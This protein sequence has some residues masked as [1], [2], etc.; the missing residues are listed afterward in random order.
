MGIRFRDRAC[1]YVRFSVTG[2]APERFLNL[3]G[4]KG[5]RLWD[6]CCGR[7]KSLVC[8]ME[9][10]DFWKIRP[11]AQKSGVRVRILE[12]RGLPFFLQRNRSRWYFG[13]G[14]ASFFMLLAV[15]SLFVWDIQIQGN[16]RCTSDS[17][18]QCLG[19]EGIRTGVR[20]GRIDCTQAEMLLRSSFPEI[21]WASVHITGTV[22][23]IQVRE[24]EEFVPVQPDDKTPCDLV[25]EES[26][27]IR[28]IVVRRGEAAV[29]VGDRVEKGQILIRGCIPL[30]MRDGEEIVPRTLRA[31]G[32]VRA[33][34]VRE[35]EKKLPLARTIRVPSGRTRYGVCLGLGNSFFT[36]LPFGRGEQ[37]DQ[38]LELRQLKLFSSFFLPVYGGVIVSREMET[39][40]KGYTQ[41]ELRIEADQANRAFLK[42]LEEKGVQILE[43]N[44]KIEKSIF[45]YRICG[46]VVT[47]EAITRPAPVSEPTTELKETAQ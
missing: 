38:S 37:W 12:R 5:L 16:T 36:F 15:L 39:Y 13:A 33:R 3:C 11:A 25:A 21:T 34:V 20:K 7:E 29:A 2:G 26:G 31:G 30:S 43:N 9:L 45:G 40:E 19:R 41:K 17:L 22:L 1:G 47:E 44:D 46:R 10:G 18:I 14:L 32:E 8:S 4:K 23:T 28:S 42:K 24:R 35:Y 6:V 27:E